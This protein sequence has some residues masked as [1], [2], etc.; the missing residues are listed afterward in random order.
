[1]KDF[2]TM[3]TGEKI[4]AQRIYRGAEQALAIAQRANKTQRVKAI[5]AQIAN[6]RKDFLHKLS[7]R[8]VKEHGAIFVG[9]VNACGLAKTKMAKSVLDDSSNA[10]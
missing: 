3:S 4:D 7:T 5:H 2:A 6:R 8:L 9:N 10:L 1:M